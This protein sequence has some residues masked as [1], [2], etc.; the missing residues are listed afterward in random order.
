MKL[1][2]RHNYFRAVCAR[3]NSLGVLT[4]SYRAS[5]RD[6]WA[7]ELQELADASTGVMGI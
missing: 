6:T 2:T 3:S 7:N 1:I 5:P 4:L